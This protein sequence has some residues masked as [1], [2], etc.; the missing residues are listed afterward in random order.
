M[1]LDP[2]LL[3]YENTQFL[4]IGEGIRELDREVEE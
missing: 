2:E 3:D 1:P 4:I